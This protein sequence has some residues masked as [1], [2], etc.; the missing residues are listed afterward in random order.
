VKWKLL[1][2]F[3]KSITLSN[4]VLLGHIGDRIPC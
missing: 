2:S 3:G 4:D 1:V